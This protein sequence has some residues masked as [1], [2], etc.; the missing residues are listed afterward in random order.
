MMQYGIVSFGVKECGVIVG[1]PGIY[2]KV[3]NYM[4]WILDSMK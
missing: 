3:S 2:T 1:A 4:N